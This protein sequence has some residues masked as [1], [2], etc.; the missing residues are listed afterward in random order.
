MI[1]NLFRTRLCVGLA[2]EPGTAVMK[3]FGSGLA[4]GL[5]LSLGFLGEAVSWE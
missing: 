1:G 5:N 3:R 4:K 2:P